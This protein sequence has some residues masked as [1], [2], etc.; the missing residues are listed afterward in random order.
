VRCVA[1]HRWADAAAG[2][3]SAGVVA[4]MEAHAAGCADC[5]AARARVA[6]ARGAFGEI[7]RAP[8]PELRWEHLGAR[9]Y[10]ATSS[11]RQ[12]ERR[13]ASQPALAAARPW[14]RAR[15][16]RLALPGVAA[17]A[18][19][20]AWWQWPAATT[21]STTPA[22]VAGVD[23]AAAPRAAVPP[24]LPDV[25]TPV[26]L[27]DPAPV[28]TPMLGLVTLAQGEARQAGAPDRGGAD[29]DVARAALLATPITAGV[30]LSTGPDGRLAVQLEAGTA[31]ALGPST[32]LD[33][34]RLDRA[35]IALH[36]DGEVSVEVARRAPGQRFV[37]IAG[38][39]QVEVR[40]TAFSVEHR[41]GALAVACSHGLVAVAEPTRPDEVVEVGAGRR[42]E[43]PAGGSL[44]D[45][46]PSP[47]DAE[48]LAALLG[49]Q[50]PQLPAW[51]DA[52]S[53]LRTTAPLSIAAA[54]GRSVKVD[55]VVVG[56]GEVTLR[57]MSGRHL[58]EVERAPGRFAAG[59]WVATRDDGRPVR[60]AAAAPAPASSASAVA[61]R[62]R[63]LEAA[64]D[65]GAMR[66]CLRGLAK[67]GLAAGTH[68]E[69]SLGVD[70][71]G[72]VS[73]LNLGDTDLPASLAGC[74]RDVVARVR[75]EPGAAARWRHRFSF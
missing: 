61:A 30:G 19:A 36:V 23:D 41:D 31:F 66:A 21:R 56:G 49:A 48:Q 32:R 52:G 72:A 71:T 5:A 22:A 7:A 57:V 75:F 25:I 64:V 11:Q 33:V 43:I 65:H 40:G 50:P 67:Q 53:L 17:A 35:T 46:V 15:A 39:R 60:V 8:G 24:A 44:L 12:Q 59:Q 63:Q 47:M 20:V 62:R 26:T 14:W 9:I 73:Y 34:A 42:W 29:D 55:G 6:S 74:V 1:P 18:V 2:R 58:V 45:A 13:T 16:A 70:A 54:P 38:D 4:R 28:P 37:V 10:W 27:Y 68:V 69:L 51:T 3:L